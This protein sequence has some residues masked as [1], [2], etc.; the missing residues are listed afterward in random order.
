GNADASGSTRVNGPDG[1]AAASGSPV[2]APVVASALGL[3][4]RFGVLSAPEAPGDGDGGDAV[5]VSA[6]SPPA[7]PVV[8]TDAAS[9]WAVG[10]TVE[11]HPASIATQPSAPAPAYSTL[12][13]RSAANF[14]NTTL[15]LVH[16]VLQPRLHTLSTAQCSGVQ[17]VP[18]LR[19]A[20]GRTG[21]Y[22][23]LVRIAV[24]PPSS[25]VPLLWAAGAHAASAGPR[26]RGRQWLRETEH[27]EEG[28]GRGPRFRHVPMGV[29]APGSD[30]AGRQRTAAHPRAGR[31]HR[32]RACGAP[33]DRA[34][35]RDTRVRARGR[36]HGRPVA[37]LPLAPAD[38]DLPRQCLRRLQSAEPGTAPDAR[39]RGRTVPDAVR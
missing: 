13:C 10:A 30:G 33:D 37:R 5:A 6:E 26:Q 1:A 34:P 35:A 2:S 38:D 39:R 4:G 7:L 31:L 25:D 3:L 17:D 19:D 28:A 24:L 18:L 8:R 11:L 12:R 32:R 9:G 36:L 21:P 23:P 29:P 22:G 27:T 15:R 16:P 14:L 20:P